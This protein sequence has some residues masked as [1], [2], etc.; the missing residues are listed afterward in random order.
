MDE[1]HVDEGSGEQ[2]PPFAAKDEVGVGGSIV[3]KL[4]DAG[5]SGG[6]A[7]ED[8]PEEDGA[9]DSNEDVGGGGGEEIAAAGPV[10]G[11]RRDVL[12]RG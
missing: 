2:T 3:D 1:T 6:D 9:V 8:H 7:V 12:L 4:R 10:A 11:G 5:I